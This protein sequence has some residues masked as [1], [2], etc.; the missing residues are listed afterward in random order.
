MKT[1]VVLAILALTFSSAPNVLAGET[2]IVIKD[3][4]SVTQ[5]STQSSLATVV[6]LQILNALLPI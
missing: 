1:L 2:I 6:A 4:R 3:R 5:Q